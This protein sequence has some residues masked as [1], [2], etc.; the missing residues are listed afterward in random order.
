MMKK[1]LAILAFVFMFSTFYN[2]DA[3]YLR[4]EAKLNADTVSVGQ[5]FDFDIV[6]VLPDNETVVEWPEF[7]DTLT[8]DVEIVEVGE[9][10]KKGEMQSRRLVLSAFGDGETEIPSQTF[11]YGRDT[12]LNNTAST[13]ALTVFVN[14]AAI[15]TTQSFKPIRMPKRQSITIVEVSEMAGAVVVLAVFVVLV[16]YFTKKKKNPTIVKTEKVKKTPKIPAIVTARAKMTEI[17][18]KERWNIHDVKQYYTELTDVVREYLE[19]QFLIDAVEMTSDEIIASVS[20]NK[21]D[22]NL[23]MKLKATLTTADLVKFAK[24]APSPETGRADFDDTNA[25]I[26]GT[27]RWVEEKS[28]IEAARKEEKQ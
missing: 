21:I 3:Q 10:E 11:N 16:S 12:I 9:I 24:A 17:R 13:R 25:F 26:E 5:R 22:E 19:G 4:A 27:Y 18:E 28:R 15:D 23:I 2:V 8:K 6:L 14:A 7:G 20:E 1:F